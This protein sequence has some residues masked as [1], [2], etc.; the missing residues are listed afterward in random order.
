MQKSKK[1][2]KKMIHRLQVS[3]K[4]LGL[5]VLIERPGADRIESKIKVHEA[6]RDTQEKC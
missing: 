4:H 3:R 1:R 5:S 2:S 6:S